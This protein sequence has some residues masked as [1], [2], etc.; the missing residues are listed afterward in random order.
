MLNK[1][2]HVDKT[3]SEVQTSDHFYERRA[4][5]ERGNHPVLECVCSSL[6]VLRSPPRVGTLLVPSSFLPYL[7]V[8]HLQP[9]L[10][11]IMSNCS[12]LSV[13]PSYPDRMLNVNVQFCNTR[14]IG[15]Q[16]CCSL[17]MTVPL[18]SFVR[19]RLNA[20][21]I[22]F[23]PPSATA[24]VAIY[25]LSQPETLSLNTNHV[26]EINPREMSHISERQF[27]LFP[28]VKTLSERL[29]SLYCVYCFHVQLVGLINAGM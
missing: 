1:S 9:D 12:N 22:F 8:K 16:M 23:F 17:E 29:I 14:Q 18:Q 24:A 3:V 25:S 6:N 7:T 19:H 21:R 26:L 10:L 15:A 4:S 2:L 28:D 27:W 20:E 5:W 11:P 13:V